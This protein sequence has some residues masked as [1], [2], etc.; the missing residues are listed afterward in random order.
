MAF[1]LCGRA[2]IVGAS[3]GSQPAPFRIIFKRN[4]EICDAHGGALH[5][6]RSDVAHGPAPARCSHRARGIARDIT[7]TAK[8]L[9]GRLSAHR[10]PSMGRGKKVASVIE[11]GSGK[12]WN[13]HTYM[14]H[15]IATAGAL[16]CAGV[17]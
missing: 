10:R 3:L 16:G 2:Y 9:E 13:G 15:A 7:T 12:L 8:G 5:R 14:S 6:G 4:R 1:P 11:Q 17:I